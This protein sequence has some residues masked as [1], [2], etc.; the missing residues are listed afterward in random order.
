MIMVLV[1]F[2]EPEYIPDEVLTYS[3][4]TATYREEWIFVRHSDRSTWEIPGGH[5]EKGETSYQAAAR[6]LSEE[7]GAL[8][9]NMDCVAT[10]SVTINGKRGWGRLYFAEVHEI[11]PVSDLFEIGEVLFSKIMPESLTYP[12]IQPQLFSRVISYISEKAG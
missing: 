12:D 2:Y 11:G 5:I 4:I 7:T 3:V 6:E 8:R 10:Y 1:E 9:F